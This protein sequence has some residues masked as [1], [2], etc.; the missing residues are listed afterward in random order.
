M[1]ELRVPRCKEGSWEETNERLIPE[2]LTDLFGEHSGRAVLP[3]MSIHIEDDKS[4]RDC[5]GRWKP[6]ASDDYTRT[7]RVVVTAIQARVAQAVR[8][9]NKEV[10]KEHDIIDRVSRH[11]RE[12]KKQTEDEVGR[13][14]KDWEK[15]LEIVLRDDWTK[16]RVPRRTT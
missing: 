15:K 2:L 6:S 12:R 5:L 10:P 8:T 13:I 1:T 4:K 9:G 7:Y 11:L 16:P 14:C 3:S